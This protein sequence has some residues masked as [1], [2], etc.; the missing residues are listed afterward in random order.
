MKF[1]EKIMKNTYSNTC[2]NA[3]RKSRKKILDIFLER[4]LV[5][6]HEESKSYHLIP[7]RF[8]FLFGLFFQARG[9]WSSYF[10]NTQSLPALEY[11]SKI[12]DKV[13][14]LFSNTILYLLHYFRSNDVFVVISLKLKKGRRFYL[15]T[16][17]HSWWSVD[18]KLTRVCFTY[19]HC[20]F[21]R[22]LYDS[23][24]FSSFSS[25]ILFIP[26]NCPKIKTFA[27]FLTYDARFGDPASFSTKNVC[28]TVIRFLL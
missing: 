12:F 16:F 15:D 20:Y 9:L 18:K 3:S 1:L 14:F 24:D 22:G 28:E 25:F 13:L 27:M 5:Y 8:F 21:I 10:Q 11:G 23:N 2:S 4:C 7:D 19:R 6:Y 26:N 17:E